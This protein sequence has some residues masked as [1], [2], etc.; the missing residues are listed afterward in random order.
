MPTRLQI[1]HEQGGMRYVMPLRQGDGGIYLVAS[2]PTPH[3]LSGLFLVLAV[4]LGVI[5]VASLPLARA[6]ARPLERLTAVVRRFGLGERGVRSGMVRKDEVGA[7]AFAF[8]DMADRIDGLLKRDR[9]L[10]ASVSHELK[11][12]LA[13]LRVA[14]ELCE[15]GS[16]AGADEGEAAS[17]GDESAERLAELQNRLRGMSDD[18]TELE[19]LVDDVMVM[20]KLDGVDGERPAAVVLR[21][22]RV[23]LETVLDESRG[24]FERHHSS[25]QLKLDIEATHTEI[26]ADP[27]LLRRVF[28]NLL[29]NAAKYAEA[30]SGAVE[31]GVAGDAAWL[32]VEIR[33][34]GPGVAAEDVVRLFEPFFRADRSRTRGTGGSG[35]GLAF[36]ASVI[37]A[38]GGE[39]DAR[40]RDGGG[41]A[42]TVRLPTVD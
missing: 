9:E 13:R 33:D 30:S 25:H 16:A 1:Q 36:C 19:Q 21:L 17:P 41:L 20:A 3:G 38:H 7:L 5:A 24:R 26:E 27:S 35:I 4:V 12:P 28:D 31:M 2:G 10:L 34:R 39:I 6:I 8:D 40:L 14:L 42:V 11:T 23:A 32:T 18:L 37:R 15:P 29:D 22:Q